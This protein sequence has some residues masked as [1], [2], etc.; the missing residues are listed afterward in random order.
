[1]AAKRIATSAVDWAKF[2]ELVPKNQK[3]VF[4]AFKSRSDMFIAR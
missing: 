2:A 1:M 4:R 3:D